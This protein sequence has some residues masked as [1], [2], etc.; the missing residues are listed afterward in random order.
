VFTDD[1]GTLLRYWRE[2]RAEKKRSP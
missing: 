1:G 2:R